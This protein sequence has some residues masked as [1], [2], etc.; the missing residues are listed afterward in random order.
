M[1]KYSHGPFEVS[2]YRVTI[3]N[4]E[5]EMETIMSTWKLWFTENI[6]ELVADKEYP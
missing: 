1:E 4:P 5:S 3:E 6:A 2:G